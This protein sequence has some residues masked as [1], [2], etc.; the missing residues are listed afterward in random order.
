MLYLY[1]YIIYIYCSTNYTA[2]QAVQARPSIPCSLGGEWSGGKCQ[3]FLVSSARVIHSR[4]C[5]IETPPEA[6]ESRHTHT[7]TRK[8]IEL[9]LQAM[10]QSRTCSLLASLPK[11]SARNKHDNASFCQQK[12]A[13]NNK[14]GRVS[15]LPTNITEPQH[16][17]AW[18]FAGC[19]L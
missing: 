2:I 7:H 10:K 9:V 13:I 12:T 15:S 4:R 18:P 17:G 11:T 8:P 16:D 6:I 14:Y 19:S 1:T 3:P 5:S